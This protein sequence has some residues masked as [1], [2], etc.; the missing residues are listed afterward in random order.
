LSSKGSGALLLH[1]SVDIPAEK[2]GKAWQPFTP[3]GVA[4]FANASWQRLLL[5]Q[6]IFALLAAVTIVWF[7]AQDWFPVVVRAIDALPTQGEIKRGALNWHGESPI[8]L[9]DNMFLGLSVD[10]QHNGSARIP[11]HLQVEFG[12]NDFR[13]LS[14]FGFWK[15]S[16]PQSWRIA[17]NRVELAPWWGAWAPPI[18]A[19][20]AAAVLVVLLTSW[21]VLATV[22]FL[23][24]WLVGL[25]ANRV[26]TSK[27]CWKLAGAA[28]M[29]GA[30]VF[31]AFIFAY[32]MGLLDIVR[33]LA[34]AGAH[35]VIGWVY[36]LVAT[37]ALPR[38]LVAER[39]RT[40]P[41]NRPVSQPVQ[42]VELNEK[43]KRNEN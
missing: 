35:L 27:G 20:V 18:L 19:I 25:F 2:P 9:A 28:L 1:L 16:Y 34:A 24:A 17:F 4:A 29:P 22:Y 42:G 3:R 38:D 31:T 10:L 43:D 37:L 30:L 33:L 12:L 7:L 21:L 23:P 15:L 40:N 13:L 32:G 6:F 41:F 8:G 5:V 26:V 39:E 14:L 36:V 11:A